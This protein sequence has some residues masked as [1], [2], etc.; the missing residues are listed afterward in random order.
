[1]YSPLNRRTIGERLHD[2]CWEW[3]RR[4]RIDSP[5]SFLRGAGSDGSSISSSLPWPVAAEAFAT[6]ARSSAG[7]RRLKAVCD[8]VETVGPVD[9]SFYAGRIRDWDESV[10]DDPKIAEI[11]TWGTPIRWPGA[12][13]GLPR[14]F[15]PTTLRYLATALW[16]KRE[17]YVKPGGTVIEVGVGFGGLAAMNAVV[18]GASTRMVDLPQVEAAARRMM[19]ECGLGRF[20]VADEAGIDPGNCCLVSNYA[21]TELAREIQDG[22]LEKHLK[23]AGRGVIVSNAG[24][25]AATIGGRSD[26]E[27]LAMLRDAGLPAEIDRTAELLGPAD[28]FCKVAILHWK[29]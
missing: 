4:M 16:L 2:R 8:V 28:H 10:L 17:G 26:G 20:C 11:D 23:R 5:D 6:G 18:S 27:L 29:A 25:F 9:G 14:A 19:E 3:I 21:F 22:Y 7:F 15:S 13:L 1:M 12:L 24:V